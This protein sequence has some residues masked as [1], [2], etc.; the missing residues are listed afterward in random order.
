[1]LIHRKA[2]RR[3]R[4]NALVVS[5]VVVMMAAAMG[6]AML[7]MQ[8]GMTMRQK[9]S[10]NTKRA[11][12]IA[13]AGLSEAYLAIAQGK[14]GNIGSADLPAQFGDGVYWVESHSMP[15]NKIALISNG[16]CGSGRF[17]ASIVIQKQVNTIA[18]L[19]MFGGTQMTV[20]GGAILDGY[21]STAGTYESQTQTIGNIQTTGAGA[22]LNANSD[23]T[24]QGPAVTLGPLRVPL[25]VTNSTR[26][27]GDAH[28]GKDKSVSAQ[29]NTSI[30]GST[31]PNTK[32]LVL[33]EIQVP[34]MVS[35]GSLVLTSTTP[36]II[37][38]SEARYDSLQVKANAKLVLKGPQIISIGTLQIE[39]TGKLEMDTAGG[40]VVIYVT[41]YLNLKSG[42]VLSSVSRDPKNV[43]LLVAASVT[44]DR[45]G[46]GVADPPVTVASSGE[47]FGMFYAPYANVL[48]PSTLRCYGTLASQ[49]LTIGASARATFDKGLLSSSNTI[50]G[51]PS[52]MSW[53]I[54]E[55]PDVPIARSLEDPIVR[56]KRMGVTPI[57]SA[58]ASVEK[59]LTITYVDVSGAVRTFVGDAASFNFSSVKRVISQAWQV[60]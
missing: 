14:S 59:K 42:S 34:A 11:L 16:L 54:V 21:D 46:D 50:K 2:P 49:Q 43:A 44:M 36:V 38:N 30:T 15:D 45:N 31:S 26:V 35:K 57:A 13:E 10:T 47:F 51:L 1:M 33:P 48:I 7:Q 25:P 8:S 6:A 32:I 4:G 12:Y 22:A 3:V 39:S 19:G 27:Y 40:P 56:L 20:G 18:S 24:V 41:D 28:P 5:L 60:N 37:T 58:A 29:A 9:Q 53:R 52:M 23:I 55:V 17:S